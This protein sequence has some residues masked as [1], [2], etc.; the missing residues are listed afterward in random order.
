MAA[1]ALRSAAA[2]K[3]QSAS[4]QLN[5]GSMVAH[6]AGSIKRKRHRLRSMSWQRSVSLAAAWHGGGVIE[7]AASSSIG[8]SVLLPVAAAP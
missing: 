6:M 2:W 1:L 3:A 7:M 8:G 5:N 4:W